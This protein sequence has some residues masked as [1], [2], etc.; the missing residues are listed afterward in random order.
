VQPQRGHGDRL[1]RGDGYPRLHERYLPEALLGDNDRVVEVYY[2]A[3]DQ[4]T[5][6][7]LEGSFDKVLAA[8]Q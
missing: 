3:A 2:V 1:L 5:A 6:K 7:E 4:E 8:V